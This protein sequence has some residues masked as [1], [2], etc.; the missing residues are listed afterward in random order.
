MSS[1]TSLTTSGKPA[2]ILSAE[3]WTWRAHPARSRPLAALH[4]A[5]A[6]GGIAVLCATLGGVFWGGLAVV[7]LVVSLRRFYFPS[8][9]TIDRQGITASDLLGTRRLAWSEVRRFCQDR[10]GAY[11][12]TRSCPSRWDAYRGVHVLFGSRRVEVL[13][14]IRSCLETGGD[15]T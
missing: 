6:I 8:R 11:L 12:S 9:F 2:T 5:L 7:L 10:H 4:G 3:P 1:C 14:A 15:T 13:A